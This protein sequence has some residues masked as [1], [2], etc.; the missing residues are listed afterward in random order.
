M[1]Q[2]IC[3]C[4]HS[5]DFHPEKEYCYSMCSVPGCECCKYGFDELTPAAAEDVCPECNGIITMYDAVLNMMLPCPDCH[6]T[7]RADQVCPRCEGEKMVIVGTA[8]E[9]AKRETC[10]DCHGTGRASGSSQ[11]ENPHP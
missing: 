7:G 9:Y 8:G 4:G 1:N 6:G 10:P 3:K 2:R 5:I 11:D